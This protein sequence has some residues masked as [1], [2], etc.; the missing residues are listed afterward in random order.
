LLP[1]EES[2]RGVEMAEQWLAGAVSDEELSRYNWDVEGEAFCI[3]YNTAP[4]DVERWVAAV[5]A[6]PAAELRSMVHLPQTADKVGPR[7][8][9]RRAAYFA[10]YAMVYPSLGPQAPPPVSYRPFLSAQVLRRHV[11]YTGRTQGDGTGG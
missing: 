6:L 3:D 1:H 8:L 5:Q 4:E 11:A 9:L 7:E 2:R 10:D